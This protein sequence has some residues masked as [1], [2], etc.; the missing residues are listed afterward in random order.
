MEYNFKLVE[1]KCRLKSLFQYKF[2]SGP[3]VGKRGVYELVR[4]DLQRQHPFGTTLSSAVNAIG[5]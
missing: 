2:V 1:D 5:T 4:G 3:G